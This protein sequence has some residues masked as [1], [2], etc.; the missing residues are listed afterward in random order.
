MSEDEDLGI[1]QAHETFIKTPK[2]LIIVIALSFIVP[3]MIIVL[4]ASYVTAGKRDGAGA[5]ALTAEAIEAR[6]RPVAGFELKDA[7]APKVLRTGEQVYKA[8][9][10][11]CHQAGVANAPKFGDV[12]AWGPRIKNGFD[13]LLN[14]VLKGKGAMAAQGN[15]DF[16]DIEVARAVVYM[17]NE[18]GAKFPEPSVPAAGKAADGAAPA[19]SAGAAPAA[20]PSAAIPA[21]AG[22]AAG[23]AA[24]APAAAAWPAMVY[25]DT[26]KAA[27]SADGKKAV[28]AAAD[29]LKGGAGAAIDITGYTDRKGNL[30]QNMELAKQRAK[31]VRT[32][33]E[34]AGV[35]KDRIHMKPPISTVADGDDKQARR[36]EIKLADAAPAASAGAAAAA[37][38]AAAVIT[39]AADA[40]GKALYESVCAVCHATGV[41]NAPKFG[42]KAA[43]AP[44]MQRGMPQLID[45]AMHGKGAM[46][47]KGGK[48]DATDAQVKSATEYMVAAAK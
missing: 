40:G 2:Q 30:A 35:A 18:S 26:G 23:A 38:P 22:A 25:F 37:A 17:A 21:A 33:L 11:T 43:W 41:A 32:A 34:S 45:A 31:A 4:L 7:N 14:S 46:P 1:D 20:A 44:R 10:T 16:D 47:A 8:Q 5:S 15:G 19:P 13:A 48:A 28:A 36:V 29:A 9:C 24:P 39:V 3:I 12:P 27:L 6:I 42:D